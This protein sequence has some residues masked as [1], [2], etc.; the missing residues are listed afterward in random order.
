MLLLPFNTF[1]FE[2]YN[3]PKEIETIFKE[4]TILQDEFVLSFM[5]M[6]EHQDKKF[7]GVINENSFHL[8][9]VIPYS[10]SSLPVLEGLVEAKGDGSKITVKMGLNKLMRIFMPFIFAI[11]AVFSI[12][13]YSGLIQTSLFGGKA[14]LPTLFLIGSYYFMM[15]TYNR[16]VKRTK[17][18]LTDLLGV[19]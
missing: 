5:K 15:H 18:A 14:L 1:I 4:N 13:M 2:T 11:M 12:G 6:A 7:I 3:S 19:K 8:A 9:R 17:Q 16:E 10:T